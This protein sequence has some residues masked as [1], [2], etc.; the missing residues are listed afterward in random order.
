[1]EVVVVKQVVG[2]DGT[3]RDVMGRDEWSA[4]GHVQQSLGTGRGDRLQNG[5]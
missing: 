4:M 3:G 1:M 5:S 2:C